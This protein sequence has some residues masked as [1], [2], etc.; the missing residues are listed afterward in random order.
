MD[1]LIKK[2][3]LIWKKIVIKLKPSD[4][5]LFEYGEYLFFYLRFDER[6]EYKMKEKYFL[7][8]NNSRGSCITNSAYF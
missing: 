3:I 7:S 1:V 5:E 8:D 6:I 4:K 2:T